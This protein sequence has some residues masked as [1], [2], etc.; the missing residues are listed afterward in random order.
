MPNDPV[1]LDDL[2]P[3]ARAVVTAVTGGDGVGKRLGDLGFWPGAAVEV[4]R[5]A[6]F[7][8]PTEYALHG[9]RL[10]LRRAEAALVL[11]RVAAATG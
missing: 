2:S 7:G 10:A 9:Y 1:T 3:G 11:V 6:P 5:R 4:G 8:D